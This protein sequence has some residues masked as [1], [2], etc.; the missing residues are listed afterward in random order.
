M[1]W[2]KRVLEALEASRPDPWE[3]PD[4]R[5]VLALYDDLAAADATQLDQTLLR[6][7]DLAYRNPHAQPVEGVSLPNGMRPGD[8]LCLEAAVFVAAER[9]L[10][11]A[12][13]PFNRLLRTPTWHPLSTAMHWLGNSA[14]A[15]QRRLALT[16]A[17]RYLGALLSLAAGDALGATLEFMTREQVQ[18]QYPAGHRD[19]TGG[20]PFGWAPGA[21]T[22]D[23]QM[24]AC[25]ARGILKNPADPVPAV[26]AEFMAWYKAGPADVGNTIRRAFSLFAR[27]G[28]WEAVSA[29]IQ[30]EL[31]ERAAGNGALMRTLPAHLAYGPADP[32]PLAIGRL[33]HPTALSDEALVLYGQV[34]AVLLAG[35][36]K[37]EALAAM[38]P[39]PR[40]TD[41]TQPAPPPSSGYVWDTLNAALWAFWHGQTLEE[42][43]VLAT[44]LGGDADTVGAV[45]GGLAGA[46]WGPLAIPRRWSLQLEGRAE[47]EALAEGLWQVSQTV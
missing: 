3:P 13:F 44:N 27:L 34:L 9:G 22:D 30:A 8:L 28:S 32:R 36:T 6:M 2:E 25:V 29:Q 20:G 23:T 12:F 5:A 7:I 21:W 40:L 33:T 37:A 31:G 16:R 19:L 15:V 11:G 17:G 35:G 26:G 42:T 18:A 38:G 24:A 43:L 47:L 39:N 46:H 45:V 41:W 4:W 10:P 1:D 14:L